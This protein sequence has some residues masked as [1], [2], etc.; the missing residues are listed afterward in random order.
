MP[1]TIFHL[2]PGHNATA[3]PAT[4]TMPAVAADANLRFR[5]WGK[6][7]SDAIAAVGWVKTADTGQVNW[8]TVTP[9]SGGS[10]PTA[11]EI[12]RAG[13]SLHGTLPLYVKFEY[14]TNQSTGVPQLWVSSGYATDGAGNLTARAGLEMV[15]PVPRRIC[16]P[17][18]SS[19]WVA[20]NDT[21][22]GECIVT[23][24]TSELVL[25]LFN[26][27]PQFGRGATVTVG[28]TRDW[29]GV[30]TAD[31]HYQ[32]VISGQG[33]T[34]GTGYWEERVA[35]VGFVQYSTT[36]I[37]RVLATKNQL[38]VEDKAYLAPVLT[39]ATPDV[40]GPAK[41]LM[42]CGAGDFQPRQ[43][44]EV[45]H[46]GAPATFVCQSPPYAG[47]YPQWGWAGP[48]WNDGTIP[49]LSPAIR[50]A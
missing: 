40:K 12:W 44:V 3:V 23:G 22:Y 4:P 46:Y 28:R 10:T 17:G 21:E 48:N 34:S 39:G 38:V 33:S 26:N 32:G 31:G 24:D 14:G 20:S 11:Y 42:A 6:A 19:Y 9:P 29:A 5:Q 37:S 47:Q 36:T 49:Q 15:T 45:T 25:S 27:G 30:P 8:S 7:I 50:I 43:R 41:W 35:K 16:F 2:Y 13:D 1:A 18:N